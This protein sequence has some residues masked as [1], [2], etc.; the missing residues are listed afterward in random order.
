MNR[1]LL[2]LFI[3]LGGE[4]VL[5][6]SD[7]SKLFLNAYEAYQQGVQLEWE[8]S[9]KEA[10]EEYLKAES[11]LLEIRKN[12][13]SWQTAVIDYRLKRIRDGLRHLQPDATFSEATS[14]P[15]APSSDLPTGTPVLEILSAKLEGQGQG[16]KKLQVTIK[17]NPK[18]TI[19]VPHVRV[20][21]F[22][23]DNDKGKIVPNKAQLTSSWVSAPVDWRNGEHELLEIPL[24]PD[25]S[26]SSSKFAG[27]QI[28]IYYKG[29]LQDFHSDPPE[30]KKLFPLK[31]FISFDDPSTI[32]QQIPPDLR[33]QIEQ[34]IR[35]HRPPLIKQQIPPDRRSLNIKSMDTDPTKAVQALDQ[36]KKSI[37]VQCYTM[38]F[39]SVGR[40]LLN[41]KKRGVDVKVILD[42]SNKTENF[43]QAASILATAGIPTYI[44]TTG[45]LSLRTVM[46]LDGDTVI[47]GYFSFPKEGENST[48]CFAVY[49][50]APEMVARSTTSWFTKLEHSENYVP[51]KHIIRR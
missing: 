15:V 39:N 44:D 4:G 10:L 29:D 22:F 37:L 35:L 12:D 46:V 24:Q 28:A 49:S 17:P 48:D 41:A 19:E 25:S 38:S 26:G 51:E 33:L 20:Q 32:E 9:P 45:K 8:G 5:L 23:Y 31:Y 18:A 40:A 36:V 34:Q 43:C 50:Q 11:L 6:A 42:K 2:C 3:L 30:L 27:Y 1:F 21:V 7:S 13:P 47:D 16:Q 14:T